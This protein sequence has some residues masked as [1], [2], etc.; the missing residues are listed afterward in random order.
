MT[1]R[2]FAAELPTA[3]DL[4]R[5]YEQ[6]DRRAKDAQRAAEAIL[7]IRA[8]GRSDNALVTVTVDGSA[9]VVVI[10]FADGAPRAFATLGTAV[11]QAHDRAVAAWQR[12][13]AQV[14]ET[15]LEGQPD[16]AHAVRETS[17]ADMQAHVDP[18]NLDDD[19]RPD[20]GPDDSDQGPEQ[21]PDQRPDPRR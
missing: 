14:S 21:R 10:D 6:F 5:I 12:E 20:R 15:T 8:R 3:G 19:Q 2:P 17:E 16:L 13:V 7:A 9:N 18:D 1:E 4:D 11:K